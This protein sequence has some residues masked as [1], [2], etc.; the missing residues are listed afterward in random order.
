MG[1]GKSLNEDSIANSIKSSDNTSDNTSVSVSPSVSPSVYKIQ[2][3]QQMMPMTLSE[4]AFSVSGELH[5]SDCNNSSEDEECIATSVFTDSRQVR[6]GSVFVAIAGEHVDGHD[7]VSMAE[8]Y[9][10]L[11]AIV[12]HLVPGVKAP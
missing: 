3:K 11:V 12:E 8:R 10:A 5:T 9:G 1:C 6:L 7:Y 4:I 2:T